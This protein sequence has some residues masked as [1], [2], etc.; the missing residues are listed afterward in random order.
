MKSVTSQSIKVLLSAIVLNMASVGA[1]YASLDQG[2]KELGEF[3]GRYDVLRN[4]M[5]KQYPTPYMNKFVKENEKL[6]SS[7]S[8]Y[9]KHLYTK[10]KE[11]AKA[12][13]TFMLN[14]LKKKKPN[15]FAATP[16]L[17]SQCVTIDK[18]AKDQYDQFAMTGIY[19]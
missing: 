7:Q 3:V 9:T 8:S 5:C 18:D 11:T 15:S 12:E 19:N 14:K 13:F 6:F 17:K 2:A 16:K 10:G 4:M 1:S